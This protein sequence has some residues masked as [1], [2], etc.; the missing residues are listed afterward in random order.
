M[1][2]Y[3]TINRKDLSEADKRRFYEHYCGLCHTLRTRH[4]LSGQVTLSFDATFLLIL[5][6]ALYEPEETMGRERCLIAPFK[7]HDYAVSEIT[8][9]AADMNVALMY[10]KCMDDWADERKLLRRAEAKLLSDKYA[11]VNAKYPEKCGHIGDCIRRLAAIE[12]A[13]TPDID[14]PANCFGELL[15]ELFVYKHDIWEKTLFDMGSALGKFIYVMDAYDDFK[16]D[17]K[18][19]NYNPLRELDREDFE[20]VCRDILTMLIADCTQ[21]FETLPIVKDVEI[22]RNALYSGVWT[23]YELIRARREGKAK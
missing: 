23:K 3:V 22:L 20:S 21:E 19:G 4:G 14:A 7:K 5:L 9:Y 15:G 12:R 18:T 17:L 6:S 8:E 1:F 11:R 13:Q 16:H 10:H 2:G